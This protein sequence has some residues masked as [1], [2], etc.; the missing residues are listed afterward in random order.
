[1]LILIDRERAVRNLYT[2]VLSD[3]MAQSN[4]VQ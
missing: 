1:M 2:E 3:E 4:Y